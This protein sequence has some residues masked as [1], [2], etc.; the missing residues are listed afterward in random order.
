MT[1]SARRQIEGRDGT[2]FYRRRIGEWLRRYI[3]ELVI[4]AL[5]LAFG[6]V[7]TV[8][9]STARKVFREAKDVRYALKFAGTQ[10]YGGGTSIYDPS[11]AT[12]LTDGAAELIAD[13]SSADGEVYLYAWDSEDNEPLRFEYRKGAYTVVYIDDVDDGIDDENAL[14]NQMMGHWDVSYSFNVLKYDAE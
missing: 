7:T 2:V 8:I 1:E 12:G 10:Y 5:L 9:T 13:L 3:I 4:V 11:K 14:T 6:I